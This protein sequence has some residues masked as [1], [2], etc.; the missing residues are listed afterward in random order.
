MVGSPSVTCRENGR[1]SGQLPTCARSPPK[2]CQAIQAPPNGQTT[3]TCEPG[4]AGQRCSFMC[5]YGYTLIGRSELTC[6]PNGI[7]D[8]QVPQCGLLTCPPV[9]FSE[10]GYT[11]G[12][13]SPGV[14]GKPCSFFCDKSYRLI[15]QDTIECQGDGRWSSPVP[16]CVPMMCKRL[17]PPPPNGGLLG[18]C[19]PGIAG[20][21]CSFTCPIGYRMIGATNAVCLTDGS[22]S[23]QP[24]FCQLATCPSLAAPRCGIATGTCSPGILGENCTFSCSDGCTLSGEEVLTCWEDGRW[25]SPA[26]KCLGKFYHL[27]S[28][29]KPRSSGKCCW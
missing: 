23:A 16:E 2:Q 19:G 4:I 3:G 5:A 29:F 7:W 21:S 12:D 25:S 26:P 20:Q 24:P 13:C 6:G 17:L 11:R 14:P 9:T 8:G 18:T 27:Q 22:W 15:G 10:S 28:H 1:W